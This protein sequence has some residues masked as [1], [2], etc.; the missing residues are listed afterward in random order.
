MKQP[1]SKNY[2]YNWNVGLDNHM[3]ITSVPQGYEG[4]MIDKEMN[5]LSR[6]IYGKGASLNQIV[7]CVGFMIKLQGEKDENLKRAKLITKLWRYCKNNNIAIVTKIFLSKET[8]SYPDYKFSDILKLL[9][10]TK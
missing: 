9:K 2:Y 7:N 8:L 5:I 3:T 6:W 10:A 1:L 4:N